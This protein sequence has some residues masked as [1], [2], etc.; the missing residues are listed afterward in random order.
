MTRIASLRLTTTLL[1][2]ADS[3]SVLARVSAHAD[4]FGQVSRQIWDAA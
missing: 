2:A 4:R 1:S 3:D